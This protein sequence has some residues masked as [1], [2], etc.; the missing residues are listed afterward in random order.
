[1]YHGSAL[2]FKFT[3]PIL[4]IQDVTIFDQCSIV[5]RYLI[6]FFTFCSNIFFPNR[7]KRFHRF[8]YINKERKAYFLI[9]IIVLI[10][11][12]YLL[13]IWKAKNTKISLVPLVSW[14]SSST[15]SPHINRATCILNFLFVLCI[16]VNWYK[17]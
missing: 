17:I 7:F 11:S 4:N 15:I 5:Y 1:M 13:Q 2:F 12:A 6:F 16:Y 9:Y 8:I 10:S 3:D 14:C